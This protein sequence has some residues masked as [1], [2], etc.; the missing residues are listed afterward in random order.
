MRVVLML[1][2][3]MPSAPLLPVVAHAAPPIPPI[4]A[5]PVAMQAV[6]IPDTLL[7]AT[8]FLPRLE[9]LSAL[10]ESEINT[11][12]GTGFFAPGEV[13]QVTTEL[14]EVRED[15]LYRHLH[16]T[17]SPQFSEPEWQQLR[18]WSETPDVT[19]LLAGETRLRTSEGKAERDA[20][21]QS[22]RD[23]T[24]NAERIAL[25]EALSDARSRVLLDTLTRIELRKNLLSAVS[26]AKTGKP[27]P[28]TALRSE[29]IDYDKTLRAA[30]VTQRRDDYLFLFRHTPTPAIEAL[31]M[32]HD[33]PLYVRFM[34]VATRTL[35]EGLSTPRH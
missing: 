34:Q 8:G 6:D 24:P 28:E 18:T 27:L 1:I 15:T 3:L 12:S 29:L 19:H 31:L 11:L 7:L 5:E 2:A 17:L 16:T 20:Y 25:M 33:D 9:D 14:R 10:I 35:R 4:L 13:E 26:R 21:L 23:K 32:R 22:L 30:L